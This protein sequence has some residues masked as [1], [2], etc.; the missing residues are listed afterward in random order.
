MSDD[1]N[2]KINQLSS[3]LG[4]EKIPDNMKNLLSTLLAT[5]NTNEIST[6]DES[7]K[8]LTRVKHIMDRLDASNHDERVILL[9]A[10]KPFLN[11][12]RQKKLVNLVKIL[13]MVSLSSLLDESELGS[14]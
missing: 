8:T 4:K 1:L 12:S 13:Q 9:N 11:L 3:I 14:S 7:L 2:Q 10:V 6:K 5:N